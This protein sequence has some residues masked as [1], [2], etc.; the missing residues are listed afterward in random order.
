MGGSN[1]IV[2]TAHFLILQVSV[3]VVLNRTDLHQLVPCVDSF[4]VTYGSGLAAHD[5]EVVSAP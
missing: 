1:L 4:D 3:L 5:R 2:G